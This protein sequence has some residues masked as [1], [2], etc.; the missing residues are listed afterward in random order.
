[1][2]MVAVTGVELGRSVG[3]EWPRRPQQPL[4]ATVIERYAATRKSRAKR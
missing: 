3:I 1:V 4:V 2:Q